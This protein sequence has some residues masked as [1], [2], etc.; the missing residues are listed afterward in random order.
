MVKGINQQ[1]LQGAASEVVKSTVM[2]GKLMMDQNDMFTAENINRLSIM[3]LCA[4]AHT[5]SGG[6]MSK[7]IH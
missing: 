1:A 2:E 4:A 5:S 6:Q 7:A 3:Q